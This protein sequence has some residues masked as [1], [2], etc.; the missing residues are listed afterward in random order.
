VRH[1]P[2]R[3][4]AGEGII[5]SEDLSLTGSQPLTR[6]SFSFMRAVMGPLD[7]QHMFDDIKYMITHDMKRIFSDTTPITFVQIKDNTQLVQESG[8]FS[9][10]YGN[11]EKS[12]SFI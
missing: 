1:F 7:P 12:G 8:T 4:R 10:I 2:A 3:L 11:A 5:E 6:L 9:E